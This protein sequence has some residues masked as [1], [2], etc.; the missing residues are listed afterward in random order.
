MKVRDLLLDDDF[1][2]RLVSGCGRGEYVIRRRGSDGLSAGGD[3]GED[4]AGIARI[5]A[6]LEEIERSMGLEISNSCVFC[7]PNRTTA[8]IYFR[9]PGTGSQIAVVHDT[10]RRSFEVQIVHPDQISIEHPSLVDLAHV[11]SEPDALVDHHFPDAAA[12]DAVRALL[13]R[14]QCRPRPPAGE[15]TNYNTHVMELDIVE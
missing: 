9:I 13:D 15:E 11:Y 2:S 5:D 12:A 3:D 1:R 4:G 8:T 7:T 6:C 10:L 14:I